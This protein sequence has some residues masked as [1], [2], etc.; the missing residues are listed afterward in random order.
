MAKS[1]SKQI[2]MTLFMAFMLGNGIQIF[3]IMF[4]AYMLYGPIIGILGTNKG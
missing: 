1:P 2:F 3:S 4:T